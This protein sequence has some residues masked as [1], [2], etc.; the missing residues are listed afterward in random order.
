[1]KILRVHFDQLR[2]PRADTVEL[3]PGFLLSLKD[4][5][6][7]GPSGVHAEFR[8]EYLSRLGVPP[9]SY[10]TVRQIHSQTVV[11]WDHIPAVD[12]PQS[13]A[14]T[15]EA[16]GILFDLRSRWAAVTVADCM[17]I[18]VQDPESGYAAILHSGWK[19]TGIVEAAVE[20]LCALAG[21]RPAQLR[22]V[23]GPAIS[24]RVYAVGEERAQLFAQRFGEQ[25]TTRRSG[26]WYIDLEAAN[27][28]LLE[29]MKVGQVRVVSSCTAENPALAS[30]RRDGKQRFVR[31]LAVAGPF[32]R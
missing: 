26:E 25:C 31:M 5:G 23:L 4:A 10:R 20:R 21:V 6:D 30:Y 22:V 11:D 15:P 12:A 8:D 3:A 7:M 28:G 9:G 24:V 13:S 19:G 14:G 1:M 29:R 18:L 2:R 16:D 17:P 27:I 32:R